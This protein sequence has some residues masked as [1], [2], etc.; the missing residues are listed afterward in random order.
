MK[1]NN[2]MDT[3][4]MKVELLLSTPE[5]HISTCAKV[6]YGT[7][8]DK[9]ITHSLVHKHKHLAALRFAYATVLVEDISI[10]CQNQ[11]VR[12][13]HLDFMVQSKRYVDPTK[14][15]F[16]FIMPEGLTDT[17]QY[18]MQRMYDTSIEAYNELINNGMKKE[19]ARAILP[20]NTSTKMYVTGNLQ[21][22]FDAMRLRVSVHAQREIRTV[23]I[24]IWRLLRD[25]YPNV[26]GEDCIING[27]TFDEW[28]EYNRK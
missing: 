26:F 23:F 25:P 12:S 8:G 2:I 3:P 1:S 20:M 28:V 9:D 16:K 10:A 17:Q 22:H 15:D 11:I 4:K 14:G 18:H 6:C 5:S 19:D 21:A 7:K 24:E 27:K 13:K